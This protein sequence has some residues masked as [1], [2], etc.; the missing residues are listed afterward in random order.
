MTLPTDL[1]HPDWEAKLEAVKAT[2]ARR[3]N[4][5]IV[6]RQVGDRLIPVGVTSGRNSD[7]AN[8]TITTAQL[9]PGFITQVA[10]AIDAN[11]A[12]GGRSSRSSRRRNQEIASYL[13]S[14]GIE[15]GQDLEEMMVEEAMRLSMQEEED[16]R[17]KEREEE[18]KRQQAG[19]ARASIDTPRASTDSP[20]SPPR[21]SGSPPTSAATATLMS[22][23]IDAP[24][25]SLT[26]Q[27]QGS[28]AATASS[29]TTVSMASAPPRLPPLDLD[30]TPVPARSHAP[31][32]A[33]LQGSAPLAPTPSVV[34]VASSTFSSVTDPLASGAGYEPLGD[35]EDDDDDAIAQ[36]A[37][38]QGTSVAR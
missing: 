34:S 5:R 21:A 14:M 16:R 9:P 6:F 4:R 30:L 37:L 8:A 36:P 33:G 25:S 2:V 24:M 31:A 12:S 3:A 32:A 19:S 1:L 13:Q 38:R 15:V 23:A 26:L 10:A 29:S 20:R 11:H 35:D 27:S 28:R 18:A 7:G 22:E 17:K